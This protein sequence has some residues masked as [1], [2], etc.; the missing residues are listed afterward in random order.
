MLE[1]RKH[2]LDAPHS[3]LLL[4]VL[5]LLLL[6]LLLNNAKYG[7]GWQGNCC[8]CCWCCWCWLD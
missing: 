8:W 6:T 7:Q 3:L 4:F 2:A 5:L 1:K